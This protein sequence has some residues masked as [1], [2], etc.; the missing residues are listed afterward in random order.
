MKKCQLENFSPLLVAASSCPARPAHGALQ[1]RSLAVLSAFINNVEVI[2]ACFSAQVVEVFDQEPSSTES[3]KKGFL[4][5]QRV[6][7][8]GLRLLQAETST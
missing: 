5:F 6:I 7:S 4:A 3:A 1:E 8:V 2:S